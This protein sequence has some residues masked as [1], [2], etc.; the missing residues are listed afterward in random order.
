MS[1]KLHFNIKSF[2]TVS[3]AFVLSSLQAGVPH[4]MKEVHRKICNPT[5]NWTW[6]LPNTYV[7]LTLT[8]K[9]QH[10]CQRSRNIFQKPMLLCFQKYYNTRPNTLNVQ[11]CW[12]SWKRF[13]RKSSNH[14]YQSFQNQADG[15]LMYLQRRSLTLHEQTQCCSTFVQMWKGH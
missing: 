6:D 14:I 7:R 15:V 9:L 11:H 12:I 4:K 2:A 1:I 10:P 13:T 5:W 3:T 8:T